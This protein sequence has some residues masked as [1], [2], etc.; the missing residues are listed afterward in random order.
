MPAMDIV[1]D[2][3]RL[4]WI[5]TPWV[6]ETL[7]LRNSVMILRTASKNHPKSSKFHHMFS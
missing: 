6:R 5:I 4:E 2:Q 7:R 3:E 1:L